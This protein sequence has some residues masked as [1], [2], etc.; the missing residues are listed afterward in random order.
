M[1]QGLPPGKKL[2]MKIKR[3]RVSVCAHTCTQTRMP[4]TSQEEK[5]RI[6]KDIKQ[7]KC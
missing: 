2:Q 3:L 7:I 5:V 4:R 6:V 1:T